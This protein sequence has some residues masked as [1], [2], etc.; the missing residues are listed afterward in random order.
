[1]GAA[2]AIES[3]TEL[4]R[5]AIDTHVHTSPDVVP[6]RL[7][8]V[9]AVRAARD[10][11]MRAIVLKSHHTATG[12][13]A[14]L[15][16][17]QV[18][19]IGVFGGVALDEAVGGLNAAAVDASARLGGVV[20]WM[21]TTTSSTFLRWI[22]EATVDHPFGAAEEGVHVL[23]DDGKPL[24]ALLDVLDAIAEHDLILATGHLD[25]REIRVLVDEA[26]R[27]RIERIVVTHPEHPYV[28]LSFE[29]QRALAGRGV[30][31]E[32]CYLAFPEQRG[33]AEPVAA[34]LAAVGAESTL[35]ATDFGQ[36]RN[37][38]P[39]EGF[40]RFLAELLELGV[41]EADLRHAAG[42]TAARLLRLD[43]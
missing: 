31:F 37:P 1:M 22:R 42:E 12:D 23:D 43:A 24:P 33:V 9:A 29:E 41:P 40:T 26:E 3:A 30:V 16:A 35:L 28:D 25:A 21:P 14:Q 7:D 10:A 36:A 19:G 32:R 5:G 11:G 15:V 18:D 4:L 27:R 20:V 8:D 39:V 2:T 13:R 38:T 6:R 17:A 34:A